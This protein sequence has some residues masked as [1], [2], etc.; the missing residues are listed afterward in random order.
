[1]D[2][3]NDETPYSKLPRHE[4]YGEYLRRTLFD[5][6]DDGPEVAIITII[7]WAARADLIDE[8]REARNAKPR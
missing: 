8:R 2:M 7:T 4:T 3:L 5:P 6:A 1:M